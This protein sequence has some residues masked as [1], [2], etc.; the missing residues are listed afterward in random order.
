[1]ITGLNTFCITR[2]KEYKKIPF[3]LKFRCHC[4][5]NMGFCKTENSILERKAFYVFLFVV[6]TKCVLPCD[7][8]LKKKPEHVSPFN[9]YTF[10]CV[11]W[12]YVSY[13]QI[14]F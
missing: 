2:K 9:T 6:Y 11:D 13:E 1:V 10:C 3:F 12:C 14:V 4:Y 5:K 7:H 8:T